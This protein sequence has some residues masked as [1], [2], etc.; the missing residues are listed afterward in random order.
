MTYNSEIPDSS[1]NVGYD[2]SPDGQY[3]FYYLNYSLLSFKILKIM[4][5][6]DVIIN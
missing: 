3:H 4:D 6:L 5:Y 1:E 2:I